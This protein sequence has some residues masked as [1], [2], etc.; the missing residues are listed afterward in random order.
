[1]R[2]IRK[3]AGMTGGLAIVFFALGADDALQTIEAKGLKFKVPAAWKSSKP[4][5]QMR[6][7]QLT[8]EPAKGDKD[9][10]ELVIFGFPTGAGTV[11]ANVERWRKQFTDKD[12]GVPEAKSKKVKGKNVEVTRVEV[13][14]EYRDPFA[15]TQ[16]A[17]PGYRLL[18]A[19]AEG[20]GGTAYFLKLV[21]PDKTVTGIK[22]D[23]DKS[24]QT[25]EVE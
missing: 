4:S 8:I 18:G 15:K 16:G 3:M 1:M 12:G 6:L 2:T 24:L 22:D 7:A 13:A 23:F 20:K 19:I 14:G 10:A 25:F 11:D 17:R 9:P 5:S 21:G